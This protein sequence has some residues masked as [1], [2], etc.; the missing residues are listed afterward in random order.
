MAAAS[1]GLGVCARTDGAE[2]ANIATQAVER[3]RETSALVEKLGLSSAEIGGVVDV[4]RGIAD[5]TNLLALNATIEAARAGEAG[6]GFAV[7]AGEVKALSKATREATEGI[8]TRIGSIQQEMSMAGESIRSIEDVIRKVNDI[9][10]SIASAVEEQTAATSEISR[11]IADASHGMGEIAQ[12]VSQV[13]IATDM[14][15]SSAAEIR[16][17]ASLLQRQAS[18]LAASVG[19]FRLK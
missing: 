14:T 1:L 2:A 8:R 17:D 19:A 6:K 16:V 3:T 15:A 10:H 18:Q 12:G 7:V 9:S 5:Q 11:S 13:S 4:I